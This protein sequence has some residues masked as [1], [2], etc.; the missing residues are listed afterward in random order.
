MQEKIQ[1]DKTAQAVPGPIAFSPEGGTEAN[2]DV[3]RRYEEAFIA[4]RVEDFDQYISPDYVEHLEMPDQKPG[5]A[6]LKQMVREMQASFS[7]ARS[8]EQ[9]LLADGDRVIE[10]WKVGMK[11]TGHDSLFGP[12]TQKDLEFSG[13][14]IFRLADGK[15]VEHWGEVNLL[16]ALQKAGLFKGPD[17]EKR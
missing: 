2:K 10:R 9:E 5:L 14:D 3:V 17:A 1:Q 7:D 12:P 16:G 4:G 8:I 6:G 15:I 11:H 13:I